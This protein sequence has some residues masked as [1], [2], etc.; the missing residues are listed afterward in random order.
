MGKLLD[1]FRRNKELD[2][3]EI[4]KKIYDAT[5]KFRKATERIEKN[6][7]LELYGYH[8]KSGTGIKPP[9]EP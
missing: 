5:E 3:E 1:F 9:D 2:E 4:V 6:V 7:H 8:K